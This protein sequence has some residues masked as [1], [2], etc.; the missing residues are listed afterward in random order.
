VDVCGDWDFDA[1]HGTK[2]DLRSGY[3]R[4]FMWGAATCA[5]RSM[6][7]VP[8]D[9]GIARLHQK[10]LA[11][12]KKSML[13]GMLLLLGACSKVP[14]GNVGILVN[15]Y[16]DSKGVQMR[17][18]GTG[19]YWLTPNENLYLFPTFTQTYTWSSKNAEQIKFQSV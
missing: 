2:A 12:M 3:V 11:A 13:I 15:L 10:G 9:L 19:R 5:L 14:P 6:E 4:R 16:G 18:V 8:V 1:V 7:L 17:E